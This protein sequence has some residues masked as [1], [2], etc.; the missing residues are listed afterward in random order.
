MGELSHQL[1]RW[2][3]L[4]T[5][6]GDDAFNLLDMRS[7]MICQPLGM[8]IALMAGWHQIVLTKQESDEP[9]H[10][11]QPSRQE[12]IELW[13][14]LDK[15]DGVDGRPNRQAQ[16]P[17]KAHCTRRL[18][19]RVDL[20]RRRRSAAAVVWR[21]G[22]LQHDYPETTRSNDASGLTSVK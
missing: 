9:E 17:A 18:Q 1:K 15:Q 7:F 6:R 16:P 8:G 14:W 22:L 12:M 19:T 2:S 20:A 4:H 13:L 5:Q 3:L 21:P 11:L 10:L